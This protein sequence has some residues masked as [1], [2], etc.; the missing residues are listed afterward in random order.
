MEDDRTG[1]ESSC[2]VGLPSRAKIGSGSYYVSECIL[3]LPT[4]EDP[5]PHGDANSTGDRHRST[6]GPG[7]EHNHYSVCAR[8]SLAKPDENVATFWTEKQG[9]F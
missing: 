4:D 5:D 9:D 7:N 6:H 2:Q 3:C 8:R 1:H